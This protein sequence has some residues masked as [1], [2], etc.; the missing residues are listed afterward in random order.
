VDSDMTG[1]VNL[2]DFAN[3][4]GAFGG[5]NPCYDYNCTKT[6]NLLDFADFAG[7]FG[8]VLPPP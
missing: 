2:L 4:A 6:V 8:H 1:T 3:F 7:H 5:A